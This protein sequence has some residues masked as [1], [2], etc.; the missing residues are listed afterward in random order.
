MSSSSKTMVIAILALI[1]GAAA[2]AGFGMMQTDEVTQ[3]LMVALQERD[4]AQQSAA[5]LRSVNDAA[6]RKYAQELGK[7]VTAA[8]A[9]VVPP[10]TPV[11]TPADAIPGVAPVAVPPAPLSAEALKLIDQVRALLAARDGFRS[12]LDGLVASMNS[13]LDA[14]ASELGNSPPDVEKVKQS[15]EA[16]K[17]NWPARDKAMTDATRRLLADLG[18]VPAAAQAQPA[19]APSAPAAPRPAPAQK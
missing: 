1:V 13:E 9:V 12:P 17:Q 10:P 2:G 11:P 6:T 18:V 3:K 15:V 14:L 7:L 19:P 16:L 4:Q 8:G 5:R